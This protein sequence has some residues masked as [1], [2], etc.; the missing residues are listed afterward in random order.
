MMPH[1]S[2]SDI[3]KILSL[4]VGISG[5][6]VM[7]G[8]IFGISVL[9]SLSHDWVSMKFDTAIAFLL[10]G[11]SLYFMARAAEG[12]FDIS[13]VV[14]SITSLIIMLF[15]GILFFSALLGVRTGVEE[16]FIRDSARSIATVVPGRPSIPTMMDFMFIA[17]AAILTILDIKRFHPSLRGIG[18]IIGLTGALAIVGYIINAPLL[19]YYIKGINSAMACHTAAL[20][21]LLGA[22]LI[23]L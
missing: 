22:G 9:K 10:S 3:A 11:I 21:V 13:Q 6:T 23:C 2:R 1:K 14:L 15:I 4:I 12:E 19:Y 17:L 20:F 18:L 5:I 8:W 7:I 16:L